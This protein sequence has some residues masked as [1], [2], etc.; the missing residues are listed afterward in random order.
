[1]GIAVHSVKVLPNAKPNLHY[2]A[3]DDYGIARIRVHQQVLREDG[4][5]EE[6]TSEIADFPAAKQP[7]TSVRAVYTL[8][9]EPLSLVK[10]DQLKLTLEVIDFRGDDQGKSALSEPVVLQVTDVPGFL[11][12]MVESDEQSARRLDAIIQRQLGIGDTQ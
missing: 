11:A 3:A 8:R 9:L 1:V 2:E 12:S 4:S 10:G 6:S 7:Q 5:M